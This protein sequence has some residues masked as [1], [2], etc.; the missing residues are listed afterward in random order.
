MHRHTE[1]FSSPI[2][3]SNKPVRTLS[4]HIV[5][6]GGVVLVVE[7]LLVLDALGFFSFSRRIARPDRITIAFESRVT[8]HDENNLGK[9]KKKRRMPGSGNVKAGET[10]W[11]KPSG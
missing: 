11:K 9:G 10:T 7:S 3:E 8:S 6:P 1:S 2:W 4:R 5:V